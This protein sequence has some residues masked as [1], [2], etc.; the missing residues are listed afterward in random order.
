MLLAAVIVC[1]VFAAFYAAAEQALA[2]ASRA[3]LDDMLEAERRAKMDRLLEKRREL[4]ILASVCRTVLEIAVV[5]MIATSPPFSGLSPY[6]IFGWAV[7]IVL[8]VS[9]LIPRTLVERAP[10]STLIFIL[11]LFHALAVPLLPAAIGLVALAR[12]MR[13]TSDPAKEEEDEAAEDILSAAAEAEKEGSIAG[14]Q[15]DMIENIIELRDV[16][17][18][19][20]MTP[21][22]DMVSIDIDDPIEKTI[23][24]A[25][26]S[27]RSR[28]PVF[29]ETRDDIVGVLYV[30]DLI[31][32]LAPAKK[33]EGPPSTKDLMRQPHFVPET[34]LTSNL[35][36]HFQERTTTIAVVVDEY[37]GTAGLVTIGDIVDVIVGEV[38]DQHEPQRE[39]EVIVVDG[40]TLEADARTPVRRLNEDFGAD[41]PESDEYDT[42]A[43]YLCA[44][45]GRV[46]Q[47]G[48]RHTSGGVELLVLAADERHVERVKITTKNSIK[49]D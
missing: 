44:T 23:D 2:E 15:A 37:G 20:I 19:E 47:T 43:G 9:E 13:K 38:R 26:K 24:V 21:R 11:P 40:H 29:R 39:L 6:A 5:L 14:E 17:V 18:A 7:L 8:V 46:P 45:L 3:K 10:E 42:V 4:A 49:R 28:L 31:A 27:G 30:R 1:L 48:D 34:M 25:L 41:I 35:L 16:D 33:G 12:L 36:R 22:P 32:A